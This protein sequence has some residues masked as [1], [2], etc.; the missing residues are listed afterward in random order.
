MFIGL[1]E[2]ESEGLPYAVDKSGSCANVIMLIDDTMYCANVGDSRSFMSTD[3]GRKIYE[4]SRDHKP[5]EDF[6]KER[7]TQNGGRIYQ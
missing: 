1:V 2:R 5:S 3:W 4:L 6:E 7:I